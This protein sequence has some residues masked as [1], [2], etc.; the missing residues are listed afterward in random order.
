MANEGESTVE[1]AASIIDPLRSTGS[2]GMDNSMDEITGGTMDRNGDNRSHDGMEDAKDCDDNDG[3]NDCDMDSDTNDSGSSD[4]SSDGSI[5]LPPYWTPHPTGINFMDKLSK[6]LRC[7]IYDFVFSNTRLT[8]GRRVNVD[9]TRLHEM[10]P[11]KHSLALCRICKKIAEEIGDSWLQKIL[12][13][14]EEVED[15]LDI[16]TAL[17]RETLSKIRHVRIR[18]ND[19]RLQYRGEGG[20]NGYDYYIPN[21]LQLL[22]GLSLDR[23][24]VLGSYD[25]SADYSTLNKLIKESNGWKELHYIT[26]NSEILG[27]RHHNA[28]K[29]SR[30]ERDERVP[31]PAHWNSLLMSRDEAYPDCSVT[32]YRA[33]IPD[34]VGAVIYPDTR[35]AF[36]QLVP[37]QHI[38]N[39]KSTKLPNEVMMKD[40]EIQKEVLVI[41]KRGTGADYEEKSDSRY[42]GNDIREGLAGRE[43][44]DV[45]MT[46]FDGIEGDGLLY[47]HEGRGDEQPNIWE[48]DVYSHVDDYVW[49]PFRIDR[50]D[51]D[52]IVWLH[53]ESDEEKWY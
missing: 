37:A 10:S 52:S 31:E 48:T 13:N 2:L 33:I 43:W 14:F 38:P 32:I 9:W 3:D 17:D 16:L 21:V 27:Y 34:C 20:I 46:Y 24:T 15:M 44:E 30:D 29:R 39:N 6:E 51:W 28:D 47:S 22:P 12:F 5:G 4:G 41:V 45:R 19:V 42:S 49:A 50:I 18:G 11:A 8:W 53:D 1:K 23:L 26:Q 25:S 7:M 40:E 35:E 36:E